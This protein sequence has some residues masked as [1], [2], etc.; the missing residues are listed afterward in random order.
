MPGWNPDALVSRKVA[1]HAAISDVGST[2][3][4]WRSAAAKH[5]QKRW[6]EQSE[7]ALQSDA[8]FKRHQ[9]NVD[10]ALSRFENVGEWA[11][12]ISFLS[13]L[14]KTLQSAPKFNAIPHKLIVAKRLSQCLNPALPSGCLLYTSDAADE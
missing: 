5:E 9:T 7:K 1:T 14:L 11:D 13:R 4:A 8:T 6:A 2:S 10:K 3:D 12:F